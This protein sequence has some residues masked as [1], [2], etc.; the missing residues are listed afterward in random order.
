[1]QQRAVFSAQSL[2]LWCRSCLQAAHMRVRMQIVGHGR[3]SGVYSR[4]CACRFACK[5]LDIPM[6]EHMPRQ[7]HDCN[8]VLAAFCSHWESCSFQVQDNKNME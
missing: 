7:L 5:Q 2:V 8:A 1:M 4:R 3:A 6:P